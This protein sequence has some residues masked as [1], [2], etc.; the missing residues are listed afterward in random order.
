M[1]K[2]YICPPSLL[3][4]YQLGRPEDEV[5]PG[6]QVCEH[7]CRFREGLRF[8]TQNLGDWAS[9]KNSVASFNSYI[10]GILLL[11]KGRQLKSKG[12]PFFSQPSVSEEELKDAHFEFSKG[13]NVQITFII[14]LTS[15]KF[16]FGKKLVEGWKCKT[17]FFLLPEWEWSTAAVGCGVRSQVVFSFRARTWHWALQGI[18]VTYLASKYKL[19][20]KTMDYL[21]SYPKGN[22]VRCEYKEKFFDMTYFGEELS[23]IFIKMKKGIRKPDDRQEQALVNDRCV[24]CSASPALPVCSFSFPLRFSVISV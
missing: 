17:N 13:G 18:L 9:K 7:R 5:P 4:Q 15:L 19:V 23:S 20:H 2:F 6:R 12:T 11:L 24:G 1:L 21:G 8:W 22:T 10:C 3:G 14:S 16:R